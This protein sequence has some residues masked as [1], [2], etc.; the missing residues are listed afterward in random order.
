[1]ILTSS[2]GNCIKSVRRHGLVS[3]ITLYWS[4][5]RERM[6]ERHLG[7]RSGEIIS[8]KELGLEH[9]ER[10]GHYPTQFTDF[11]LMEKFL[12]PETPNEVFIDYGAG[13]GRAVILA[14]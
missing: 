13:L 7:I 1:M 6:Q 10:R 14:A 5:L 12:R 3:T 2:V 9:E 8:V 11:R 4:R